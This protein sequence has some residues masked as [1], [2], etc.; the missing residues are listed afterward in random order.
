[1]YNFI[2]CL[3]FEIFKMAAESSKDD[4][5]KQ[6]DHSFVARLQSEAGTQNGDQYESI[7]E[8][9]LKVLADDFRFIS[10]LVGH[11][12]AENDQQLDGEENVA[13]RVESSQTKEDDTEVGSDNKATIL[14]T[15]ESGKADTD[16]RN[17]EEQTVGQI[18]EEIIFDARNSDLVES[19]TTTP[20][21][22]DI[23]NDETKDN[24]TEEA[25][26]EDETE[27]IK[28]T[29]MRSITSLSAHIV[30]GKGKYSCFFFSG[31]TTKV[32]GEGFPG[33]PPPF[34][35]V[36]LQTKLI[37]SCFFSNVHTL[38]MASKKP[39]SCGHYSG[40]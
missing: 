7:Q 15:V 34:L 38:G 16:H 9:E 18:D 35:V 19:D 10:S 5:P 13:D 25:E 12:V 24:A 3:G 21:A 31:K 26:N 30:T 20:E 11:V 6:N 22:I 39:N 1:M 23:K 8:S 27:T 40:H 37:F 32:L 14:E 33:R 17:Q 36:R 4:F 28:I 29:D 2:I